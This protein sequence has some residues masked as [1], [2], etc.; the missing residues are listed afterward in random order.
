MTSWR[1]TA[2]REALARRAGL[3]AAVRQFFQTR[4]VLE[5]ETPLL[6][7]AA[8]TDIHLESFLAH[9]PGGTPYYLQTSPE[10]PMKR[11]LAAGSGAIYQ[12]CKVFRGGESGTRHNPE[13]TLLEWYRPGFDHYQLMDEVD[14]LL[15]QLLGCL[16]AQRLSYREAFQQQAAIDPLLATGAELRHRALTLGI[17]EVSLADSD[18]DGWLDLLLTHQVAPALGSNG[19]PCFLYDYPASQAALAKIRPG[20]PPVAERFEVFIGG[21]ELGNGY[22]ELTN[23]E[24]QRQRFLAD[25]AQRRRRGLPEP[26]MDETLL[27][28]LTEGLPDCAGIAIG[29]DRLLM[30]ALGERDIGA[31]LAFPFRP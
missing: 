26:P 27:A 7:S 1:P 4:G 6:S 20:D 9:P 25:L 11:L 23:A 21:L 15:N 24:E 28:A 10:F 8:V 5:V 17:G 19:H 18:R 29:L 31:V 14:E 3:L 16:P 12:I 2:S 22:H 30:I 13:F